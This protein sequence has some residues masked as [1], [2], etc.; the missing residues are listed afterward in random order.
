M[1]GKTV[2]DGTTKGNI[3][4]EYVPGGTEEEAK[5]DF[6]KLNPDDVIVVQTPKGVVSVGVLP[7]GNKIILRPS[8][9]G[10]PTIEI[11]NPR[12][13]RKIKEIR[14]GD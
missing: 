9:D 1:G 12:R 2:K 3:E 7:N 11:Q 6:D 14:Y 8:K 4:I 5:K 10:R 13:G